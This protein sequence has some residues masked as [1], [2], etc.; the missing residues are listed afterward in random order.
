MIYSRVLINSIIYVLNRNASV[1]RDLFHFTALI[2][3]NLIKFQQFYGQTAP[4][5]DKTDSQPTLCFKNI[6]TYTW[7]RALFCY[8]CCP[9]RLLGYSADIAYCF[10]SLL[11]SLQSQ[12]SLN[13]FNRESV[14]T[15]YDIKFFKNKC[16]ETRYR[17]MGRISGGKTQVIS[18]YFLHS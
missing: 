7:F 4:A 1:T 10:Y 9:S 12:L 2:D 14:N 11:R 6:Q 5:S 16:K 8:F 15:T 18:T 13:V 17:E 3:A